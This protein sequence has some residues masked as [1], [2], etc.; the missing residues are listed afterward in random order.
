MQTIVG[1]FAAG[2]RGEFVACSVARLSRP[3]WHSPSCVGDKLVD[4][5]WA[6]PRGGPTRSRANL[7]CRVE[8]AP[9]CT[10]LLAPR[11]A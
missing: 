9:V 1:L 3:M 11:L 5:L 4:L 6:I 8:L 2:L 10:G 7:C